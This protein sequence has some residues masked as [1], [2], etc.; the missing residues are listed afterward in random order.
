MTATRVARQAPLPPRWVI[1]AAWVIHRALYSGTRGR[2]GLRPATAST[3]GMMRLRTIGR[4]SG[5]ER[6]A[7]LGYFEDGPNLVTM[8]MNGWGAPEPAWWLNLQAQPDTVVQLHDGPRAVTAA[9]PLPASDHACGHGGPNTT[10]RT[11]TRGLPA[12]RR[13]PRSSSSNRVDAQLARRRARPSS[14]S[15]CAN[16]KE[17]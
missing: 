2:L 6:F 7:I 4:R 16:A 5:A 11:W 13:R 12:G 14:S 1:R 15:S 10:A 17:P 3:W 8:A 9:L